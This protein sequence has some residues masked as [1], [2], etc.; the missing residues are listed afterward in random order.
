M[1]SILYDEMWACEQT[2]WWFL[3]RRRILQSL[4]ERYQD[5]AD[6]RRLAVCDLGCGCGANLAVWA[7]D[8]EVLGVDMVPLAL[9]YARKRLGD[10]VRLGTLPDRLPV[11]KDSQDVVLLA[12][13]LEHVKDDLDAARRAMELLKPGGILIATVPAYQWLTSP[14]DV[15]HHHFR[16]YS[17]RNF[18]RLFDV[19][20]VRLE[21]LSH[22]NSF[23]FPIAAM[24]RLASRFTPLRDTS[25]DLR[26]PVKPVNSLLTRLFCSEGYLL[27][28][29]TLPFGLSLVVVARRGERQQASLAA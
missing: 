5:T 27:P 14:R 13:V 4:V 15:H 22:Y 6:G 1:N 11:A 19:P 8:H 24:V 7:N 9:E 10:R 12:D 17:K 2:H 28:W 21:L 26:V 3:G 20:G 18:G 29:L 23:L 16:R 25:G